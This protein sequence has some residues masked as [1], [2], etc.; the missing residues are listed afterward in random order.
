MDITFVLG[1]YDR[2]IQVEAM[3]CWNQIYNITKKNDSFQSMNSS[4]SFT[5]SS[6]WDRLLGASIE[7]N[8]SNAPNGP[9]SMLLLTN[10][11]FA[12][13]LFCHQCRIGP[14]WIPR[15]IALGSSYMQLPWV[16][17]TQSSSFVTQLLRSF[18][19]SW[20]KETATMTR[21]SHPLHGG[22][23]SKPLPSARLFPWGRCGGKGLLPRSSK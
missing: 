2:C 12:N 8:R 14:E 16:P 10:T 6:F 11:I 22:D 18:W 23:G 1:H 21:V 19:I 7:I 9:I 3:L 4:H 13:V 17:G 5:W 20:K 15:N